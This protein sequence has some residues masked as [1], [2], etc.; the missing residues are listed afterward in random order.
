MPL[1]EFAIATWTHNDVRAFFVQEDANG[2]PIGI[3]NHLA[4]DPATEMAFSLFEYAFV[5]SISVAINFDA[6]RRPVLGRTARKITVD[7]YEAQCQ[8]SGLHFRLNEIRLSTIF[9]RQF[10]FRLFYDLDNPLKVPSDNNRNIEQHV[11]LHCVGQGLN[12]QSADN[13]SVVN[14]VTIIAEEYYQNGY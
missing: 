1:P 5:E 9:N 3:A 11:F 12:L 7:D 8:I 14:S 2:D 10:R 4:F 13:A 6:T